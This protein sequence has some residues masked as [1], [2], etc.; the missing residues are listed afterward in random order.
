MSARVGYM[1]IP[2]SNSEAAAEEMCRDCGIADPVLVPLE[3]AAATAKALVTGDTDYGV[4]A[5]ENSTAGPVIETR[6]ALG[7]LKYEVLE[8]KDFPIHHCVFTKR[9]DSEVRSVCSHVQAIGQSRRNLE[10]MFPGAVFQ[11]CTDTAVAAE[12]LADGRLPDDCAV[13][14]RRAA[15]EHYGLA[16]RA[17]NVEDMEGNLTGFRLIR[18]RVLLQSSSCLSPMRA[19]L[20]GKPG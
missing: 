10:R 11:E 7:D 19:I 20:S 17:E 2:L 3:T 8:S 12:M 15:G 6:E 5:Y 4:F 13:V 16:L 18:L 9:A 1:G 14:C